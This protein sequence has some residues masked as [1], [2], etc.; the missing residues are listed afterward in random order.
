MR[1]EISIRT[2]DGE[3]R[4]MLCIPNGASS[5]ANEK[6]PAVILYMDALGYRQPIWDHAENLAKLGYVVI[7]PD[8]FY[9]QGPYEPH[10]VAALL[11]NTEQRNAWFAERMFAYT[12]DLVVRDA[13]AFV[14]FLQSRADVKPAYGVSGYCMGGAMAMRAAAAH[15]DLIKACAS[16]HGGNLATDAPDSA[17]LLIPQIKAE[18]F[19][20]IAIEDM[21]FPPEQEARLEAALKQAGAS[22]VMETIP[23]RHGFTFPDHPFFNSEASARQW[24]TMTDLFAR[25]LK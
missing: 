18:L 8:L 19:F 11:Q 22:Y 6:L 2:Q 10:D 1:Q 20:G 25:T 13:D 15:P 9:R 7:A 23:A 5:R 16:Y 21:S 3:C 14:A 4:T 17:H 24:A 12:P